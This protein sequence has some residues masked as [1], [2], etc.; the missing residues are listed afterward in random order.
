[1]KLTPLLAAAGLAIPAIASSQD[2]YSA[3]S[4]A[5]PPSPPPVTEKMKE[6]DTFHGMKLG[7]PLSDFTGLDLNQDRGKLKIYTKEGDDEKLGPALLSEI[8]YY[9]FDD[10]LLGVAMHGG[11]G[12]DS[13]LLLRILQ[14]AYGHGTQ[15]DPQSPTYYWEGETASIRFSLNEATGESEA[16]VSS[17]ELA[18]AADSYEQSL[19]EESAKSL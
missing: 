10:K 13:S 17:N 5:P 9:F 1:M 16:F 2:S 18:E 14:A 8:V 12:Q 15:P 7:A 6:L 3:N 19:V 4:E 11:D